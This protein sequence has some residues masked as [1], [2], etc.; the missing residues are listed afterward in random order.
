MEKII[1][2]DITEPVAFLSEG[3][4]TGNIRKNTMVVRDLHKAD[5]ASL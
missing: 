4:R 3:I 2:Y 1:D 5:Y